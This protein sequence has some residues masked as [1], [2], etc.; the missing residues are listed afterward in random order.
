LITYTRCTSRA[1]SAKVGIGRA[2]RIALVPQGIGSADRA[3]ALVRRRYRERGLLVRDRDIGADITVLAQM[4]DE[5]SE[6]LRRH[7]LAPVFGIQLVLFDPV[8]VD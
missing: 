2:Q 3:R 1:S 6:I 5:V 4:S 7:R 8:I